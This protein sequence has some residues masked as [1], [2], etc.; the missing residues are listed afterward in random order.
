MHG[1]LAWEHKT[2]PLPGLGC[3]IGLVLPPGDVVFKIF[4]WAISAAS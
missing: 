1:L 4:F 3:D 2:K